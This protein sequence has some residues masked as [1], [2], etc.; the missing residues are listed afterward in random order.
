VNRA[1]RVLGALLL[2]GW[3]ATAHADDQALARA[4]D[5]AAQSLAAGDWRNAQAALSG[6]SADQ[7]A[8]QSNDL[9]ARYLFLTALA[10]HLCAED[11]SAP[12]QV[13]A[14][15]RA[16]AI[17]GYE[18][19]LK[20][21]P[22]SGGALNNLAQLYAQDPAARDRALQLYDAAVSQQDARTGI[23]AVN[24]AK[25]LADMGRNSDALSASR[26]AV[27]Q[28]RRNEAAQ[29]LTLEL[30]EKSG[31]SADIARFVRDLRLS[32]L[33]NRS[34]ETALRELARMPG[35]RE[36]VLVALA[37]S[38]AD[39]TLSELPDQF[40]GSAAAKVLTGLAGAT[41]I[42]GG[43][44]ELLRLYREPGRPQGFSWWRSDFDEHEELREGTRAIALLTLARTLG[45]RCR[46]A[47]KASFDCA[48]KYYRFAIDFTGATADPTAFLSLAQV[49]ADTGRKDKLA[50][51]AKDYETKLFN[52]KNT[53]YGRENKPRIVQFH[54]ALGTMYSY[55]GQWQGTSGGDFGGA[56]GA[57]FQL[58]HAHD[59]A[60]EYNAGGGKPL[61]FSSQAAEMLADAYEKGGDPKR[62]VTTR[63]AGAEDALAA[64]DKTG[65]K[66]LI[67]DKSRAQVNQSTDQAVKARLRNIDVRVSGVQD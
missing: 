47:G 65:A 14:G 6:A 5:G 23:Y 35:G 57:I 20:V 59:V 19:Y 15:A 26:A 67:N 11:A 45:D 61:V 64:G 50:G 43:A 34:I 39:P 16:R 54:L 60:A 37:E 22:K 1:T 9:R 13:R 32:G 36:A 38:L 30:L 10:E 46:R 44:S 2:A 7:A 55:L 52:G 21:N 29:D 42:G 4:L 18:T 66:Q 8:T 40:A 58:Q 51:I 63:L 25:L 12:Q 24:R 49:Y 56:D 3:F 53:A 17:N 41:D 62:S 27:K 48:E 31:S 33:V 28:D